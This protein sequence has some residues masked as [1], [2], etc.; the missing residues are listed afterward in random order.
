MIMNWKILVFKYLYLK[1]SRIKI[2]INVLLDEK[3]GWACLV[4]YSIYSRPTT[5]SRLIT[6]SRTPTIFLGRS[7]WLSNLQHLSSA[8]RRARTNS[9]C[10][11]NITNNTTVTCHNGSTGFVQNRLHGLEKD[12]RINT[13]THTHVLYIILYDVQD[14]Y[15][16]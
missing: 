6:R 10:A 9:R 12:R 4:N 5:T 1:V 13:H 15:Y 3:R 16:F 8:Q 14:T 2:F 11:K 7:T